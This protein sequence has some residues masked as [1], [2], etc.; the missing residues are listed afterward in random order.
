MPPGAATAAAVTSAGLG[1]SR[2]GQLGACP[3]LA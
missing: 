3:P 1:A 2:D